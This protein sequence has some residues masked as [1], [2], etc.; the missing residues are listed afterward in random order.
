MN[1]T[2]TGDI[3]AIHSP[4]LGYRPQELADLTGFTVRGVRDLI[5]KGEIRAVKVGKR[6][7]MI[8]A[9]EVA[10]IVEGAAA[11]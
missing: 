1:T 5:A 6:A 8:P 9:S 11:E 7:L 10:R 4:R 2:N 3:V